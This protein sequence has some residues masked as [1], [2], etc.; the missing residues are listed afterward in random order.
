MNNVH[1]TAI[2][3]PRAELADGVEIGPYAVVGEHVRIGPRTRIDSHVVL[4]GRTTM[5]ADC[6]VFPFCSIGQ[7]PQDLKYAGEPTRLTIGDQNVFREYVTLNRGTEAGG[8][9]TTIGGHNFFMAYV[10]VAHDCHI[11]DHTVLANAATLAGHITIGDWA[12][13]GGLVGIHQYVRIGAYAM[14]GGCSGLGQDVPPYVIAAGRPAMLYALNSIGLKRRGFTEEQLHALKQAYQVLFRSG[15]KRKEA[16]KRVT[17]ECSAS[18]DAMA[19]VRF[20]EQSERGIC[21]ANRKETAVS[22]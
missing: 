5:G 14:I 11:G 15:L 19:L 4:D 21:R 8:G 18:P 17:V 20:I 16:I 1:P 6:Q 22:G 12:T 7:A 2:V 9:A 3:H 10:H 13:V